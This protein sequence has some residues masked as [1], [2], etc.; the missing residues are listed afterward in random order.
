MKKNVVFIIDDIYN[1]GG[2]ARVTISLVGELV[3]IGKYSV[4]IVSLGRTE[5]I[6]KYK[7]TACC[8]LITL[9]NRPFIIRKDTIVAARKLKSLFSSSFE[10]TFVVDDVGHNIPAYL[11]L[12]HCKK[13]RFISWSHMNFFNGSRWGFSGWGKRLAVNR[14]DYLVALTKEDKAYYEKIL[15]A[16][17]VI[18]I[19]NPKNSLVA[20]GIYNPDVKKIISCGRLSHEKGF[21]LLLIVAKKVFSVVEDWTWDIYGEGP[22]KNAL[23]NLINEY[24]LSERVTLKG[25]CNNMLSMYKDYA[26][27]V[28][29]SRREGC[30]M[31]L[32]EAKTA[33][34]PIIS[35]DFRCGPRDLIED[36]AN[37]FIISDWD[38]DKMSERI[39]EFTRNKNMRMQFAENSDRNLDELEMQYVLGLWKKIL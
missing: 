8:R 26:L 33:G 10:G 7:L 18:Q 21:D 23:Q 5:E 3:K 17:N 16:Q 31:A 39:I 2:I 34:L 24:G 11:G 32:I 37:G 35:F 19:Y 12:H 25:Y 28:F 4:T 15:S 9:M 20:K 36:G 6:M 14:F 29:T 13:A 27:D 38:V 22:E 30:P 1:S